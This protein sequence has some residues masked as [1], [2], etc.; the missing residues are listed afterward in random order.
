[1]TKGRDIRS[2]NDPDG[3]PNTARNGRPTVETVRVSAPV[4]AQ[5]TAMER[6]RKRL[7]LAAAGFGLLF[8]AVAVQLS[9]ACLVAPGLTTAQRNSLAAAR[10]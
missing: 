6:A 4:L 7:L 5:R 1:M 3:R 9:L 8:A 10:E 2:A